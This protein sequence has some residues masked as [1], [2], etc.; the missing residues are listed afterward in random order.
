LIVSESRIS[1]HHLE[2]HQ[3][4]D[5][6][7]RKWFMKCILYFPCAGMI[8]KTQAHMFV[9]PVSPL[10]AGSMPPSVHLTSSSWNSGLN[11]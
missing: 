6:C 2:F 1:W 11:D 9:C 7:G 5:V 3:K 10:D 4:K 8:L